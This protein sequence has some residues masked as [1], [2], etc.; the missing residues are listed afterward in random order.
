VVFDAQT[1]NGNLNWQLTGPTQTGGARSF[2][3][4]DSYEN[5]ANPAMVL[6]PGTYRLAIASSGGTTGS[7]AF[8]LAPFTEAALVTLGDTQSLTLTPG[9]RTQLYAFDAT[10]GDKLYFDFLSGS[11]D[12]S[13]RLIDPYGNLV[14]GP[15]YMDDIEAP[16]LPVSGRYTLLIE[17]R[18]FTS[19]P[20]AL[21]FRITAISEASNALTLGAVTRGTIASAGNKIRYTFSLAEGKLLSAR[22]KMPTRFR[23]AIPLPC[24][25]YPVIMC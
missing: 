17:G 18:V 5:G 7:Y 9:N 8:R 19:A 11:Q 23:G 14:F 15:Q 21:Q 22:S 16:T 6:A 25:P 1:Y 13:L 12:P 3:S 4:T 20:Q 2:T 10:A 24:S